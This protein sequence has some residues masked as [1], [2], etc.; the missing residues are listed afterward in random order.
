MQIGVFV[1]LGPYATPAFISEAARTAERLGFHS[2]WAPEHVLLFDEYAAHYPYTENGRMRNASDAA[3]PEPFNLLS[4]IA[5]ATTRIRLGTGI[6]LVPQRNPVYTAKEVATLDYLSGGRVDFGV[7]IGWQQEEF[8]ALGVPWPKRAQRTRA[9]LEVMRRLWCDPVSSYEGEYYRLPPSRQYPK[10]VQ[11]P[12]P[13]I[14]F[15]GE[16]DAAL[17]RVAEIGHG[18]FGYGLNPA[19]TA[20][21]LQVLGGLLEQRGRRLGEIVVSIAPNTRGVDA[22]TIEAYGRA[23]V[24]QLILAARG[25]TGDD[26]LASLAE[27]AR[28]V[29]EPAAAL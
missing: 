17:R 25:R 18:W 28:S 27:L 21:R 7:G 6:C 3:V 11:Q 23:G 24:N 9:Y 29:V 1:P 13:P 15:G 19:Q 5:G 26:L 4:F 16:S 2:I 10:P 8:A 14:H 22:A 12:H 20:E